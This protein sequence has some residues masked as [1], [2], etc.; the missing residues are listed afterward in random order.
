M[1]N[2]VVIINSTPSSINNVCYTTP[3][4]PVTFY[5][6]SGLT[7]GATYQWYLNDILVS[8]G[9]VYTV[10]NPNLNDEIYMKEVISTDICNNYRVVNNTDIPNA[11]NVGTLRYR[12]TSPNSSVCEMVMQT[13]ASTYQWVNIKTNSW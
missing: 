11:N 7:E 5:I 3:G 10:T 9:T 13:G 6:V 4:T 12:L 1:A 8:I 2:P